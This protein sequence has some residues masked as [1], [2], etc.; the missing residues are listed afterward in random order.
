VATLLVLCDAAGFITRALTAPLPTH[1]ASQL[2]RLYDAMEEGDVLVYDRAACSFAHFALLWQRNLHAIFRLHQGRI[3]SFRPGRK[4][5]RQRSKGQRA[6]QPK[7]QWIKRLGQH[8]QLVRWFK[9]KDKP[10]WMTQQAYDA[11]PD[12]LVLRELRYGVNRK[13][14]RSQ[15]VTLATTL[16]DPRQYPAAELAEQ[17]RGRWETSGGRDESETPQANHEDGRAQVQEPRRRAQGSGRVHAGVQPG[18][19]GDAAGGAATAGAVGPHQLHRRPALAERRAP[20][21]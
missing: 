7:S 19:P 3:V 8:D 6:G 18:A 9:P 17:F 20:W 10:A 14:Y 5:A 15:T 1:D 12:S 16:L 11:L 13:G 2:A 21:P 4:H